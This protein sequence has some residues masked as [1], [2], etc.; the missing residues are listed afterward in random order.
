MS[1]KIFGID[2][3]TGSIKIYKRNT[4]IIMNEKCAVASVGRDQDRRPVAMG[5]SAF[6]MYEKA[7]E[8]IHVNFPVKHGV[9]ADIDD[10]TDLWDFMCRKI[11]GRSRVHGVQFLIAVPRDISEVEK[12][13][14][15]KVVTE[16]IL[17]PK[18]VKL[19]DKPVCD[20]LG[21]DIDLKNTRGDMIVNIGAGTTEISVIAGNGIVVSKLIS[22]G[23]D[24]IDRLIISYVKKKYNFVIGKKSAE[25]LK[26][27]L[28]TVGKWKESSPESEITAEAAGRNIITGL[29]EKIS[30]SS[31]EVNPLAEPIFSEIGNE[32]S[33]ILQ[34]TP[35][36]ISA[37]VRD[38]G[39]YLTGGSSWIAGMD[40]LIADTTFCRVNTTKHAQRS[41]ISGLG[42]L[43]EAPKAARS[44]ALDIY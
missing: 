37:S 12:R 2:F 13:A 14:F 15:K 25:M 34:R 16:G 9:I 42:K 20:A 19:I 5:D 24:D 35:P 26:K 43:V 36:E 3:G 7:P 41:V 18:S 44:F 10:M 6:E 33:V 17:K 40:Q 28:I 29:P 21:L 38:H 4:G 27:K 30:L 32:S 8:N 39:I 1:G 11:N 22:R 23:G 31:A